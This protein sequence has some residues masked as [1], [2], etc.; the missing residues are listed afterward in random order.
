M[1]TCGVCEPRFSAVKEAFV[2]NFEEHGELGAA[3]CVIHDGQTVVDLW[4][5]LADPATG[6]PWC[7]DT[8]T[9]VFSCSKGAV[10]LCAHLLAD[11]GLLDFGA[12]VSTYW[13]EFARNG[14][15]DTTV[16]MLLNHTAGIP[17][18]RQPLKPGAF[19]DWDYMI[20]AL[21][22]EGPFWEPGRQLAY[23]SFN[24]GW[25]GGEFVRRIDG[26][27]I[28][29]FFREEIAGPLGLDFW[30]GLPQDAEYRVAPQLP[31]VDH[32]FYRVKQTDPESIT[33]LQ[34]MNSGGFAED[35]EYNLP[36][37]H[38]ACLPAQGGIT[39][40]RGLA[41]MYAPLSL[42]GSIGGVRLVDLD[43]V[44]LMGRVSAATQH[45]PVL[46]KP[47]SYSFGFM[48]SGSWVKSALAFGHPGAGGSLGF[49]DPEAKL[50]FGYV[51]NQQD[52]DPIR[53]QALVDSTYESL[54]YRPDRF[55]FW[56][57]PL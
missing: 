39:N 33:A 55:G 29:R 8:L 13:P 35:E 3:V 22:N 6:R 27:R 49:A 12:P 30:F 23:H 57:P 4:G 46:R 52:H 21:E 53:R 48:K 50:A 34:M 16:G 40:A 10:A 31:L 14:K 44:R 1:D 25:L 5:G 19:Y 7:E 20:E 2:R 15:A 32:L 54:G 56:C 18:F 11:R 24:I 45:D 36:R 37:A 28:D 43:T 26:R 9:V 17:A 51:M 42:G 47:Y 41:G 38:A